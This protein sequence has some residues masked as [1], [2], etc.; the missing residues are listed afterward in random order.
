METKNLQD[1]MGHFIEQVVHR[2]D[3]NTIFCP[4][5]QI[6]VITYIKHGP[7][8]KIK[9][10]LHQK[11]LEERLTI[12]QI[13]A[14]TMSSRST[15]IKYLRHAE[16]PIR[17]EEHRLGRP[18]YGEKK[19]NGRIVKNQAEVDLIEKVKALKKQGGAH[20]RTR[21]ATPFTA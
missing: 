8:F 9:S 1:L 10:F 4:P 18:G 5:S 17:D 12:N 13:A 16:I 19:L 2:S 15:I 14:L 6:Q 20:E 21:T 3:C 7:L 11:Y